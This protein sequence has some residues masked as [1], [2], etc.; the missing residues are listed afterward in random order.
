MDGCGFRIVIQ[1]RI[2]EHLL[3]L[4]Q[5]NIDEAFDVICGTGVSGFLP[6]SII[7]GKKID[8]FKHL[9][10]KLPTTLQ[11]DSKF[12]FK[13][14]V[15]SLTTSQVA[16]DHILKDYFGDKDLSENALRN[17]LPKVIFFKYFFF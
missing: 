2:L 12:S 16:L 8:Q 3:K 5:L 14:M 11:E 9:L 17:T 4:I 13:R 10:D 6:L 15:T 1:F 7:H